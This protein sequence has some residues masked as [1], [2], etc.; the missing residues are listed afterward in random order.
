MRDAGA[1][2]EESRDQERGAEGGSKLGLVQGWMKKFGQVLEQLKVFEEE[3]STVAF[4]HRLRLL[5]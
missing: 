2:A 1:L 3:K 5:S 4:K